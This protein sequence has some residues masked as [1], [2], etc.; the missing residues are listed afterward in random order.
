MRRR[1]LRVLCLALALALG[2]ARAEAG[3]VAV[4]VRAAGGS[5]LGRLVGS[6]EDRVAYFAL[7]DVARLTRGVVRASRDGSRATLVVRGRSVAVRRDSP[8][9]LVDG[10]TLGLSGPVRM[11]QGVWL[12]PGDLLVRA[13]PEIG[14]ASCR[15][16]V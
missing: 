5:S 16:R 12:V 7:Q 8:I 9:V 10:R 13:L 3:P 6:I 15:E 4:E 2:A 14:R 11:R 1:V